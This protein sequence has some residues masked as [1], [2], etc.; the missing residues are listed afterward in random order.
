MHRNSFILRKA[1]PHIPNTVAASRFS[2]AILVLS[3]CTTAWGQTSGSVSVVSNYLFRG[4]SLSEGN[5]VPQV[6][7]GYDSPAGWYAGAFATRIEL[8]GSPSTAQMVG[9]TGYTHRW[10]NGLS[11]EAGVTDTFYLQDAED[12]YAEVFAG[13]ASE[14]FS[15]R[16]YFAPNYLGQD[17]HTVY[18]EF[19][20]TYSLFEQVSFL[21][22][23]GYF[24][25]PPVNY[26]PVATHA[27]TRMGVSAGLGDWNFQLAW[28]TVERSRAIYPFYPNTHTGVASISYSF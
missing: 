25:V 13:L 17:I 2:L 6:N 5:P 20:A 4:V 7:L 24:Y 10:E 21:A 14:H 15:G 22:H 12:N 27:D 19:N 16:V 3:M 23:V 18:S 8:A 28:V 1:W 9:Y 26:A 11:W